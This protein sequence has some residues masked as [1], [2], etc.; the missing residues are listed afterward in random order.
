MGTY[1][2]GVW[3]RPPTE[4]AVLFVKPKVSS[5]EINFRHSPDRKGGPN[6]ARGEMK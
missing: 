3:K 5:L 4:I 2:N 1:V 6:S